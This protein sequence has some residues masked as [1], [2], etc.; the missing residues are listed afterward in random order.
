MFPTTLRSSVFAAWTYHAFDT[1]VWRDKRKE[2]G[3]PLK[4]GWLRAVGII[5]KGPVNRYEASAKSGYIEWS[6]KFFM[7][8]KLLVKYNHV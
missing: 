1:L 6:F 7:V 2:C 8:A 3:K 5:L 4:R